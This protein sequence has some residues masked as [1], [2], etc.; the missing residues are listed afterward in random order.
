M[1][2]TPPI[3]AGMDFVGSWIRQLVKAGT[4]AAL[5]PA[6][7]VSALVVVVVGTGG[8]G[9]IGS[10]AQLVTGP[11]ISTAERAR[12]AAPA[13]AD[14][15]AIV[16]P[17]T[18]VAAAPAVRSDPVPRAPRA[19]RPGPD[20]S[21]PSPAPAPAPGAPPAAVPPAAAVPVDRP[22]PASPPAAPPTVSERTGPLVEELGATVE[23]VVVVLEKII[24]G[25]GQIVDRIL[26]G[27]PPGP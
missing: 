12:A 6:A 11:Q 20:R 21:A 24:E 3:I 14:E 8:L 2:I 7:M 25:L 5:V 15:V 27:P 18:I 23:E 13:D 16:A 17:P 26:N 1:A 22:Q 10:L 19:T 4:A 9:G